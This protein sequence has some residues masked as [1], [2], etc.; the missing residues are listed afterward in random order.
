MNCVQRTA[1]LLPCVLL[2]AMIAA[3]PA[4][5]QE[6]GEK[7]A[8]V[9]WWDNFSSRWSK[10]APSSGDERSNVPVIEESSQSEASV[11]KTELIGR[12]E[13]TLDAKPA[14]LGEVPGLSRKTGIDGEEQYYY[15][16]SGGVPLRLS[17]CRTEDLERL[18]VQVN[19]VSIKL[20]EQVSRPEGIDYDELADEAGLPEDEMPRSREEMIGIIKRR[21]KSYDEILYFVPGLTKKVSAN[22][23]E[24]LYYAPEGQVATKL[25]QL[26][27]DT[28]H[29]LFVRVNSEATRLNTERIMKQVRQL[30]QLRR[31]NMPVTPPQP[32]RTPQVTVPRLPPQPP[33]VPQV[34]IPKPPP[35][36]NTGG[37][38]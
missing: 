19:A 21:I 35:A 32:P 4:C 26:D 33:K 3:G 18:L 6:N 5:P 2:A 20:P 37:R 28:L 34:N 11:E 1:K 16:V 17:L 31:I 10:D 30:E 9:K 14:I 36:V 12:I 29:D 38:R 13:N 27:D 7:G 15:S 22:G 24:E 23:Q 8:V 25:I